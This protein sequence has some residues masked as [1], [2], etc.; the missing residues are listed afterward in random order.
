[1]QVFLVAN[2]RFADSIVWKNKNF[3][4]NGHRQEKHCIFAYVIFGKRKRNQQTKIGDYVFLRNRRPH[5]KI[6]LIWTCEKKYGLKS[7]LGWTCRCP[8]NLFNVFKHKIIYVSYENLTSAMKVW[9][10]GCQTSNV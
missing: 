10:M 5:A 1:M 4:W 8:F 9:V 6:E 3:V 7:H 2:A